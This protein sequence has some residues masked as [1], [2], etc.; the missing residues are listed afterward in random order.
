[1]AIIKRVNGKLVNP[2]YEGL[3]GKTPIGIVRQTK[4][5]AIVS[6]PPDM[7]RAI[8][9]TT[10][11]QKARRTLFQRAV[12]YA[13]HVN[14]T[15]RLTAAYAKKLKGKRNV[16]QAALSAYMKSGGIRY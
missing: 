8:K 4:Q 9:K 6:Y 7:R 15:P 14:K 16:Y 13:R 11:Q 2:L 5:G 1:M 3:S 10:A 12:V